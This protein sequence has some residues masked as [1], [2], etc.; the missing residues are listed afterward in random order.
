MITWLKQLFCRHDY[1]VD[2]YP[3][4]LIYRHWVTRAVWLRTF[5]TY[6]IKICKK[7]RCKKA[8][9]LWNLNRR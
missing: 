9:Y 3:V 8:Y 2:K 4:E 6:V 5:D 1:A 7:C